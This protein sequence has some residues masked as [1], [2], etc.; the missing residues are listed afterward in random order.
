[1]QNAHLN[2]HARFCI[3]FQQHFPP[4]PLKSPHSHQADPRDVILEGAGPRDLSPAE[5]RGCVEGT[6]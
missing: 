2:V 4:F 1:M 6:C 3:L 5:G